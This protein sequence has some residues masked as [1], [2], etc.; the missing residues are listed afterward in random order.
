MPAARPPPAIGEPE[1]CG[2]W[3]VRLFILPHML[4]GLVFLFY[5]P[6]SLL[7]ALYGREYDAPVTAV[8]L[9]IRRKTE[10]PV[11]WAQYSLQVNGHLFQSD[12]NVTEPFYR[13][14]E[15]ALASSQRTAPT[16]APAPTLRIR[17]F[18]AG[19]FYYHE[20]RYDA[21]T[22]RQSVAATWVTSLLWNT[23]VGFF[24][25]HVYYKPWRRRRRQRFEATIIGTPHPLRP[26]ELST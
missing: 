10:Q 5:M 21:A 8:H 25:Y 20:Q 11:Y 1:G 16:T 2:L 6:A 3:L 12:V 22:I 19:P 26:Q 4:V 24:V 15:A 13:F 9:R 7:W 14:A 23:G 17:V 18:T